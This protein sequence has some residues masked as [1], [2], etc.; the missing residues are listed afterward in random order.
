MRPSPFFDP[1]A[2]AFI[3][4]RVYADG[5]GAAI[6]LLEAVEHFRGQLGAREY[7]QHRITLFLFLLTMLDKADLSGGPVVSRLS[8]YIPPGDADR[9]IA[10]PLVPWAVVSGTAPGWPLAP[11]R[12]G[13]AFAD[14]RCPPHRPRPGARLPAAPTPTASPA[15]RRGA[16]RARRRGRLPHRFPTRPRISS[17]RATARMASAVRLNSHRSHAPRSQ[18]PPR[19]CRSCRSSVARPTPDPRW[20]APRRGAQGPSL[21]PRVQIQSPSLAGQRSRSP[22]FARRA[23]SCHR[24]PVPREARS[25]RASPPTGRVRRS[26]SNGS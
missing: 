17:Y 18:S 8:G 22:R 15:E 3:A 16:P 14:L 12:A 20:S 6:R 9:W 11:H 5:L 26:S 23:R 19:S 1:I 7:R 2:Q 10:I 21:A 13:V 4:T 25:C 24:G